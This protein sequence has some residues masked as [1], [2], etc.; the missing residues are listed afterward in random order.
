MCNKERNFIETIQCHSGDCLIFAIDMD[1]YDGEEINTI[2]NKLR[3]QMP[4]VKIGVLPSDLVDYMIH[5][6]KN[7]MPYLINTA[8]LDNHPIIYTENG[9][10][11]NCYT[12]EDLDVGFYRME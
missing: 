9:P 7:N 6:K 12:D 4:E 11:S 2:L 5:I 10:S 1:C 3:E 8:P